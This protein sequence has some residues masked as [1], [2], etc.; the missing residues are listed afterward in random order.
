MET[1]FTN[2]HVNTIGLEEVL[3]PVNYTIKREGTAETITFQIVSEYS[4]PLLGDILITFAATN[5]SEALVPY[6]IIILLVAV[7]ATLMARIAYGRKHKNA[8][9]VS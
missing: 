7:I 3:N 6:L 4:K 2:L 8:K 1:S 9:H 5:A